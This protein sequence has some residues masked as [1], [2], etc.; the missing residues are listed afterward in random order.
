VT[1]DNVSLCETRI[2]ITILSNTLGPKIDTLIVPQNVLNCDVPQVTLSAVCSNTNVSYNWQFPG[3]AGNVFNS[4]VTVSTNTLTPTTS[5][6]ATYTIKLT[7]DV[8]KCITTSTVTML[9]NLFPPIPRITKSDA[10]ITCKTS[11]VLL[12]NGS[13]SSIPPGFPTGFVI[14]Y[15]WDG[16]SP[17]Q[18]LQV[19]STYVALAV[20]DYT[21]VAKD[22]GN[23]CT[24][25]TVINVADGKLYPSLNTPTAPP[26]GVIDCGSA[27]GQA[28][29]IINGPKDNL[30][31]QW[32]VPPTVA[33]SGQTTQ[34]LS[35]SLPGEYKVVVTNTLSGC[36]STASASVINGSLS[37]DMSIDMTSGYAPLTVNITNLSASTTGTTGVITAWNFGNGTNSVTSSA[38]IS[39]QTVFKMPGTYTITAFV[40]KGTC[41]ANISKVIQVEIPSSLIVPNVFTP[42]N[43]RIND[44]FF[45]KT[46]NLNKISIW[47]FD[48]WGH[49][50]YELVSTKGNIAWDGKNQAGE[51]VA[52]G[53]YMYILKA[54]G[55][56]GQNYDQKG[57]VSLFR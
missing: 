26:P 16:P 14:G 48:R 50:V 28:S 1:K 19:N 38:S 29:V 13:S 8:N 43:D 9:Q 44:V 6:I 22:L 49:K 39:P 55:A 35:A 27:A 25:Q 18:R 52:E 31:Y 32:L 4:S 23:G 34:Y 21:L 45:I 40:N 7:D 46:A 15:I 3:P 42:N 51:D 5:V 41:Q 17:M 54:E 57:N 20:G 11:S 10:A 37:P 12:T 33:V 53:T 56:D 24:S 47:I 2:P 30:T 36:V